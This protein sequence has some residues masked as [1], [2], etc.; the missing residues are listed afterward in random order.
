MNQLL[1]LLK[2]QSHLLILGTFFVSKKNIEM[3]KQQLCNF[4]VDKSKTK[5][6]ID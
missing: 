4:S 6:Y 2:F 3:Q 1:I 5:F